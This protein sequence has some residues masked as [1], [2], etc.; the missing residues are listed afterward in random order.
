[1]IRT[2]QHLPSMFK[3]INPN[4]MLLQYLTLIITV[5]CW[6]YQPTGAVLRNPNTKTR[7]DYDSIENDS[8]YISYQDLMETAKRFTEPEIAS[9]SEMLVDVARNQIIVGARDTLYRMSFDLEVLER[10]DWGATPTQISMCQAKGQ[11]EQ[12]C[13]NY[14]RVLQPYGGNLLYACGTSA[15][16]PN[17]TWRQMENLTVTGYDNGVGKCPFNPKSNITSLMTDNG[18]MFVGTA[19]DFSGGDGAIL[20]S[21]VLPNA[22]NYNKVIRTKQYN[23]NWLN[24][25]QFVGSFEAG[26]FVY[27]LFREPAMEYINCGKAIYSRIAR[28]CKNDPGGDQILRDNWTSFL[29]ARLNCSLPGEYPFYF[30][31]IQDMVYSYEEDVLYATFTTPENSIHGSAVCAFNLSDINEAFDGPF[32][33]QEHS[34][35][36][37]RVVHSQHN[38]QF[39]CHTPTASSRSHAHLLESS[40]YQLM[41]RAVQPITQTP[42]YHAKLERFSHIALDTVETKSGKINVLFVNSDRN[43]IKKLSLRYAVDDETPVQTCLVEMWNT[44]DV[45]ILN[46][47]YL[48]VTDSLYVGSENSLTRIP[49]QHCS[50]HVSRISCLNAMDPY[51]GWN[52]L[53][54][55]CTPQYLRE[56]MTKYWLQADDFSCPVLTSP[57]DGAWSSWSNWYKCSKNGNDDGDCLCRSRTCNN[58]SPRNGGK[59]C[60][61]ITTEVT[62]CTVHGGWTE[63][64]AWSA[65][66]QTCGMAVKTRRRTCSNPKPAFG[67]RT[68]VG[69]ER[70]EMYCTNLPPCPLPKPASVDGGWGPWGEW[71]ECSHLCGGGFRIRRRECNDP[72]PQNGGMECP[73]CNIDYEDCNMQSCPEVKKLSGWTPWLIQQNRTDEAEG[74]TVLTE[75]RFR[76]VCRATTS[77]VS[78][79]HIGVAK[80]ENRICRDGVCQ[81]LGEANSSDEPEYGE[82]GPCNVTCGGGVQHRHSE[83]S[84]KHRGKHTHSRACNMHPCPEPPAVGFNEVVAAHEWSCW[85]DW[86]PCS[87]TCGVGIKRRT[88]KCLGGH[89]KLCHGRA[90]DE[91]KCEMKPCED[92]VGWS[93]WSEWSDCTKDGIRFR[94]RKCLVDTPNETECRGEEFEKTAC[95]PGECEGT[96]MA[97]TSTV[98]TI[99]SVVILLYATTIFMTFWMTRR[100]YRPPA[101]ILKNN[102]PSPTSYD[103]Y[104]NQ[105]SSLPTKDVSFSRISFFFFLEPELI[106]NFVSFLQIYDV[107]P[108]V[109]RQSS[110][111]MCSS[112]TSKNFNA[113]T[114][115]RNNIN[116]NHTPKVLAKSFNDCETG[117]LK[118]TSN[119]L[120]NYRSNIDDE[121]F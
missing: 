71:S 81:R 18:K 104:P 92:F 98:V 11:S 8:R 65:C 69:S 74:V 47:K 5:A 102:T 88:R 35:S 120:N 29:K 117:T 97:S 44:E 43:V 105:Y 30:D 20:K 27:F 110:F 77:D 93:T 112:P 52:E 68:C 26:D 14:V 3:R 60:E 103:S 100:H 37:W 109:K 91:E 16:Y 28:V 107:R 118:R 85:T 57:I 41:D 116:H 51:C 53:V 63:W 9:Y 79:M 54:D 59:D 61:G 49:A 32:K 87:V 48:R 7:A 106:L 38:S 94:H 46:M 13:R 33:H 101:P 90:I 10:A 119:A 58:P 40:K 72:K 34:D 15:F 17:C 78:S 99:I 86:S 121:K 39:K 108:K 31:E 70:A 36:P 67:G 22:P 111:N 24:N 4:K 1:M 114:L 62:N 80:T 82:W 75:K 96:Q 95:V 73:G 6:V 89:D 115:N 84:G 19:T 64:S 2:I 83:F 23:N 21:E 55:K 50:R 42:L 45:P 66:S 56:Q 76:F 25:P 113:G 12:V